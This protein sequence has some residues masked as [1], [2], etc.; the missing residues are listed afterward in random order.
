MTFDLRRAEQR[1]IAAIAAIWHAGWNDGHHGHVEQSLVDARTQASFLDRT[2]RCLS[3]TTV[4][5]PSSAKL[6]NDGVAGFV[7]VADDEVEQVYVGVHHR[8]SGC[9]GLLLRAAEV[10]IA[11][12][13]K[14]MAWLAVVAGNDRARSF[15]T[16]QGWTD[17][18]PATYM[19][20]GEEDSDARIPVEAHR[21]E[22]QLRHG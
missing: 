1:H 3:K 13:D 16:R 6:P 18:G 8:G 19:A 7:T 17:T 22:K 11:Q 2:A 12:A 15:Y 20:V 5:T 21:Y 4:A 9:A 10:Q 14:P